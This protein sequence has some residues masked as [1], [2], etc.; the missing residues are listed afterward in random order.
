MKSFLKYFLWAVSFSILTGIIWGAS[1]RAGKV[2]SLAS[3]PSPTP[4][5]PP[6]PT[7]TP[8][9]SP[10]PTPTPSPTPIPSPTPPPPPPVSSQE[11]NAFIERFAGQYGVSPH[12]L[13]HIA[14]CESGFNPLAQKAGYAGLYQFGATTWKN[15]RLQIGEDP[16]PVLRLNAEEA[17]QTAAFAL[18]QGKTSIWP[19]CAP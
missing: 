2:L 19:N 11:I 4:T 16:N 8:S 7:P 12:V 17:V 15:F 14:V 1:Y 10:T 3:V 18:S 9:P 6:T 5:A 13:R